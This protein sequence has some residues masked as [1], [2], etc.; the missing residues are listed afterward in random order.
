MPCNCEKYVKGFEDALE[1]IDDQLAEV[2]HKGYEMGK[3]ARE[4]ESLIPSN[5]KENQMSYDEGYQRGFDF[6]YNSCKSDHQE[7]IKLLKDNLMVFLR[8]RA[9]ENEVMEE[10]LDIF[11]EQ[12]GE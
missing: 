5:T 3:E 12:L 9:V 11:N 8:E 1:F 2:F 10:L 4:P 7:D 6:G